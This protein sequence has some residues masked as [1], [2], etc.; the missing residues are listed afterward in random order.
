VQEGRLITYHL[1]KI[2]GVILEYPTCDV[3]HSPSNE[4]F[5]RLH[6]NEGDDDTH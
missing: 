5:K 2:S 3:S 1:E 6:P 4:V